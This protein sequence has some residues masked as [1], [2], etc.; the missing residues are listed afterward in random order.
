L[1]IQFLILLNLHATDSALTM[2]RR[3]DHPGDP[4]REG[5]D[6]GVL[7]KNISLEEIWPSE[8][9]S[10]VQM[11]TDERA[12]WFAGGNFE[13]SPDSRTLLHRTRWGNTV[14]INLR[15][16]SVQETRPALG[17]LRGTDS[18]RKQAITLKTRPAGIVS[19]MGIYRQ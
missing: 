8:R 17:G 6:H 4:V 16:G 11:V 1:G 7:I 13:F 3:R 9:F 10:K 5:P 14:C 18:F 12:Q 15:N 2:Y 19:V